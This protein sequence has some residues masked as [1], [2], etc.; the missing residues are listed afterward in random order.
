MALGINTTSIALSSGIASSNA[1]ELAPWPCSMSSAAFFRISLL[2][3]VILKLH[4]MN[5]FFFYFSKFR[6]AVHFTEA[7]YLRANHIQVTN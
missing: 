2:Y 6:G 3:L 5:R 7:F 1:I 4:L